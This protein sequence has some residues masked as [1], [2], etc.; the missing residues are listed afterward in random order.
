MQKVLVSKNKNYS[1][2]GEVNPKTKKLH[3]FSISGPNIDPRVT[4]T[5]II[6]AERIVEN[7][8]KLKMDTK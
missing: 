2:F 7:L 5:Y 6:Q 8:T 4:Y 1:I 3:N